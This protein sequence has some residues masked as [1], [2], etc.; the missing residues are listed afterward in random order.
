MISETAR[1]PLTISA[2]LRIKI[3][4]QGGSQEWRSSQKNGNPLFVKLKIKWQHMSKLI[5][6]WFPIG[7]IC[8]LPY[9]KTSWKSLC[10]C[11]E[12]MCLP[13]MSIYLQLYAVLEGCVPGSISL[14]SSLQSKVSLTNTKISLSS[15]KSVI[16]NFQDQNDNP[17]SKEPSKWLRGSREGSLKLNTRKTIRQDASKASMSRIRKWASSGN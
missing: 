5:Q 13:L 7:P 16:K 4:S 17:W 6:K 1:K 10:L 9:P 11:Q 12:K 8:C 15:S 3:K 2:F 14:S